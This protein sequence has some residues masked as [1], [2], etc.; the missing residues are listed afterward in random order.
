MTTRRLA[1]LV[2]ALAL[3]VLLAGRPAAAA[4]SLLE[5][6]RFFQVASPHSPVE[7]AVRWMGLSTVRGRFPEMVGT[8]AI[9]ERDLTRSSV[10]VV[11]QTRSI[12]TGDERRDTHLRSADFFDVE[13]F[14][15][16]TFSSRE[17]VR[18]G[19][20]YLMRGPLTIHGVTREVEIPVVLNGRV[21]DLSG[22]ERIGFDARF[23]LRRKDYGVIGPDGFNRIV[24]GHLT[25]ADQVDVTIALE[26]WSQG[27]K[28]TLPGRAADSLLRAVMRRGVAAV[29]KDYRA[30]RARV[31]DSLMAVDEGVINAVGYALLQRERA[32][33]A[34][35]LFRLEA[36]TWPDSPFA[37][38]GLGQAYA[39]LG[40]RERAIA[41]CERALALSPR[42]MRARE[43][44]RRA[45]AG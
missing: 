17:V 19:A 24:G 40:D 41:H 45:R 32:G 22:D 18:D 25:I 16:M 15:T 21:T 30:E 31:P 3:P 13:R 27:I 38:V 35:A 8:L 23:S 14:P 9:D 29:A 39:V 20:N 10:S 4:E 6:L 28:D 34:L 42:A 26:G 33:D 36:E 11:I 37:E 44:L 5:G 2:L 12:H 43:I 7:F 1:R